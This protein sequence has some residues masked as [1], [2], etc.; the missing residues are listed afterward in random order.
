MGK[1]K[2]GQGKRL[3]TKLKTELV[4]AALDIVWYL[5]HK[6]IFYVGENNDVKH[7]LIALLVCFEIDIQTQAQ[8]EKTVSAF[9][10]EKT[11]KTAIY[12]HYGA[13]FCK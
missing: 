12:C 11:E 10:L 3:K 7:T 5:Q 8:E 13:Q 2:E 6:V 1:E 9:I 4:W